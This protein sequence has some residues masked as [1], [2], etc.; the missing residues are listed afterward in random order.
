MSQVTGVDHSFCQTLF[1][2][3]DGPD[4]A[5]GGLSG[6][7]NDLLSQAMDPGKTPSNE[8]PVPQDVS[9]AIQGITEKISGLIQ[10]VGEIMDRLAQKLQLSLPDGYE[11][12]QTFS[13]A[14]IEIAGISR[15]KDTLEKAANG[16][17]FLCQAF[18][19][20]RLNYSAL[21]VYQ[22]VPTETR[23]FA[24]SITFKSGR[25]K[26]NAQDLSNDLFDRLIDEL[27]RNG[28]TEKQPSELRHPPEKIPASRE[29]SSVC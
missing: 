29:P 6:N 26:L 19:A 4:T 3:N 25:A 20:I 9:A 17:A 21:K 28:K 14:R 8:A 23:E 11:L 24:L 5:S 7:F 15:H 13:A 12:R 16:N 2:C 18:Q 1:R 27:D 22:V 10:S